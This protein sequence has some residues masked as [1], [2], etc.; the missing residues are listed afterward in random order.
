MNVIIDNLRL[1]AMRY[2]NKV[3]IKRRTVEQEIFRLENIQRLWSK[4][5]IGFNMF[6]LSVVLLKD[7]PIWKV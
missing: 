5:F 6:G 2:M 3:A 4:I 1:D 7:M